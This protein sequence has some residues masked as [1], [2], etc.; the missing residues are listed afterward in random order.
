MDIHDDWSLVSSD[1]GDKDRPLLLAF[2]VH[3]Q[4]I[5]ALT[6]IATIPKFML[7][8]NRFKASLV[9]QKLAASRESEAFRATQISKPS[10]PLTDVASAFFQSAR[11]RIKADLEL[12][13]LVRQQMSFRLGM[14]R[15]ILF[16][17]TMADGELASFVGRDVHAS[18]HR[19][20]QD[21]LPPRREIHLSFTTLNISKFS[22]LQSF[23]PA[24]L[25]VANDIAWVDSL[26]K[27]P[28]ESNIIGLPPMKMLMITEESTV[29]STKHL[30]YDFYSTFQGRGERKLEDI[31]I[32][33]N[34]ALYSW[35]TGLRKNLSREMDQLTAPTNNV[36]GSRKKA[37][38]SVTDLHPTADRSQLVGEVV[39]H[40]PEPLRVVKQSAE[41]VQEG[42]VNSSTVMNTPLI[43]EPRERKIQKLTL[44]QLG[45]AT[46]D[47]MHP[48]FMKKSGFNL[49]DSLPQYVHEYATLPLEEIMEVLLNL[50]SKQLPDDN[51]R[52]IL[53]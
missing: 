35:L 43:Y 16:P 15:L 22:R 8:S 34:V 1:L 39:Q 32:T 23:L 28:T 49:E 3:G 36:P 30:L 40:T 31:Y 48:F 20:V 29:D 11:K 47:V 50:Y 13:Y 2:T 21:A 5:T 37:V 45:E 4:G 53:S 19:T 38:L 6:T 25:P 24:S 7:Y 18:L 27:D 26:F 44:R 12:S 17:R 42:N 41:A 33:L 51:G 52:K 9:A 46:P 10:N 14:L